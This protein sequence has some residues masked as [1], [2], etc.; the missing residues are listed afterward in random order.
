MLP[1]IHILMATYNGAAHLHEQLL[2]IASQ[3]H[4]NWALWVSDDGSTDDTVAIV[5]EFADAHPSRDIRILTGPGKG[6]A[7]NFLSLLCH[8]NLPEGHVALSDQDDIWYPH[9][10]SHAL[11]TLKGQT[12]PAIYSAQSRHITANGTPIRHSRIHKGQPDFGNALVQNRI[13]GHCATLNPAALTLVRAVG[14]VDVP[15]HDWWLYQLLTGAG[16]NTVVCPDVVLDY[17][18]HDGNVLG[19]N[20]R[21]LAGVKRVVGVLGSKF[22]TWQRQ[23]IAALD[24]ARP[25]LLA[26]T[27]R[28]LDIWKAAPRWG[29]GRVRASRQIGMTRD[30]GPATFLIRLAALLGR[31]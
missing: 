27:Q 25:V 11:T 17:R 28:R 6:A 29:F 30:T 31:L 24:L 14:P 15:F 3:D 4:A 16:G 18:Q 10:L 12:G 9:K 2:S 22:S 23:N 20:Q 7:A 26:Q 21:R 5:R 8:P 19:G 1:Q 13:A